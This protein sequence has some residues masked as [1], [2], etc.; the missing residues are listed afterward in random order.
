MPACDALTEDALIDRLRAGDEACFARLVIELDSAL[1]WLARGYVR[2]D[3]LV[4]EVVQDTWLAVINGLAG[5]AGRST[6][7][8]WI[9]SILINRA[10]TIAVRDARMSQ[11]P[12]DEA[13]T[14]EP[15]FTEEGAWAVPPS[16]WTTS[17]P[18]RIVANKQALR[19]IARALEQLP[20]RQ[21][22][23]VAL[24][25]LYGWTSDETCDALGLNEANQRVLLHRGRT[26]LRA[27]LE[28]LLARR[29]EPL[30]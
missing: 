14:A 11:V 17:D 22:E 30:G 28:Q 15:S 10:R 25:D 26:R 19:I 9:S 8:T 13:D 7:R 27:A 4:D 1:R 5:F 29:L 23:V 20:P 2:T 3:A 21:R 12:L 24:R 16:A 18:S 6:I